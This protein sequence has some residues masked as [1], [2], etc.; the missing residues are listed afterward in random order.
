MLGTGSDPVTGEIGQILFQQVVEVGPEFLQPEDGAAR[1]AAQFN[2]ASGAADLQ[3]A[4]TFLA[5]QPRSE[6]ALSGHH[7]KDPSMLFTH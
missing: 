1:P 5:T 4:V 2:Q 7:A 6:L 3:H